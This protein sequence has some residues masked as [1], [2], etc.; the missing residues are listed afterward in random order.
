MVNVT[1]I[2]F[3]VFRIIQ[4]RLNFYI[5]EFVNCRRLCNVNVVKLEEKIVI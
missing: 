1:Y 2:R 4:L 3:K 5:K